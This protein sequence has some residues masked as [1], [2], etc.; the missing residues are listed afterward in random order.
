MIVRVDLPDPLHRIQSIAV[1]D[2]ETM[3]TKP[4]K[5]SPYLCTVEIN[6]EDSPFMSSA[7]VSYKVASFAVPNLDRLV[8]A[9][10]EHEF[11]AK[12]N[13]ADKVR[14]RLKCIN[15]CPTSLCTNKCGV[16][17]TTRFTPPM[18]IR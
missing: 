16:D 15:A 10:T 11:R 1:V 8:V 13:A 3:I 18:I 7:Q 6:A 17:P 12:R 5:K 9:A 4:G 2:Y 14:M